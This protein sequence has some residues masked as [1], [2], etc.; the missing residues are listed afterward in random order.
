MTLRANSRNAN[1]LTLAMVSGL[2]MAIF[3]IARPALGQDSVQLTM[4]GDETI[5]PKERISGDAAVGIDFVSPGNKAE[6]DLKKVF[7]YFYDEPE[8]QLHTQL[9]TVDGRYF[10]EFGTTHNG[11][12]KGKWAQLELTL[13]T[14]EPLSTG[15]LD[16]NYDHDNEIAILV[17]DSG[18]PK[19]SFPVRW[20]KSCATDRVR[21]RVNAE[22]ADAYIVSFAEKPKGALAKCSEASTKSHFK[23]DYNCDMRLEDLKKLKVLQV[24]RKRGATYERPIQIP[25]ASFDKKAANR[26]RDCGD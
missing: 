2:L 20:G 24:I 3:A 22:G 10:A 18:N 16:Q 23:F 15:F 13:K 11:S 4:V 17:S 1:R 5:D 21:L 19:K 14:N 9:T 25:L 6:L 26:E 12:L 7:V 8:G